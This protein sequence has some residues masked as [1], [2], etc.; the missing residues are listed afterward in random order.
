[1]FLQFSSDSQSKTLKSSFDFQ[2]ILGPNKNLCW[3]NSHLR[4]YECRYK[5]HILLSPTVH[6][7]QKYC[8]YTSKITGFADL[9]VNA[10]IRNF[11]LK[12]Y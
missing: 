7:F 3:G 8:L 6:F 9:F 5:I 1:M 10:Q 2:H 11:P 4:G 12:T